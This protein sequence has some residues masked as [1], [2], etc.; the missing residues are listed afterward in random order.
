MKEIIKTLAPRKVVAHYPKEFD[1]PPQ[2][3]KLL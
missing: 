1:L 3:I 2:R